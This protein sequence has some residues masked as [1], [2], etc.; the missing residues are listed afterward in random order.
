MHVLISQYNGKKEEED[1]KCLEFVTSSCV[2]ELHCNSKQELI[3]IPNL[4]ILRQPNDFELNQAAQ[5]K[6]NCNPVVLQ[7]QVILQLFLFTV[8]VGIQVLQ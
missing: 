6:Y 4:V 8:E 5:S 3:Q 2:P 7:C 1:E